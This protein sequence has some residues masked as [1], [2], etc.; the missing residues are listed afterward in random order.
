[1]ETVLRDKFFRASIQSIPSKEK[2]LIKR[3]IGGRGKGEIPED[4]VFEM[5]EIG[6]EVII[7]SPCPSLVLLWG[8]D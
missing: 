1:M 8:R 2:L 5:S 3:V 6:E 7:F 4:G